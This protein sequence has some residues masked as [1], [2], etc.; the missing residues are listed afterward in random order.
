M[1][2]SVPCVYA[3]GPRGVGVL[4]GFVEGILFLK[5]SINVIIVMYCFI[6]P[7][8]KSMVIPLSF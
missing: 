1:T 3:R 7:F 6:D 2:G 8:R 4:V 5:F